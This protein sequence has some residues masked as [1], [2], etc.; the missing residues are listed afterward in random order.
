[1]MRSFILVKL[2]KTTLKDVR[3]HCYCASLMR[4][5][6]IRHARATSCISSARTEPKLKSWPLMTQSWWPLHIHEVI[7]VCVYAQLI[8]SVVC[9][10][11]SVYMSVCMHN[12]LYLSVCLCISYYMFAV[13][14]H[15]CL[16]PSISL[17]ISVFMSAVSMHN[18]LCLAVCLCITVYWYV[19]VYA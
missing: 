7:Y 19:C 15:N 8:M 3:A 12:R 2:L 13:S 10:C 16:Y 4:T 17:C 18:Y 1:M 6:F 14:M 11:I 5:L 9:L